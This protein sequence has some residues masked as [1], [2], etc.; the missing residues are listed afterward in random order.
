MLAKIILYN[1]YYV[2]H[3]RVTEGVAILCLHYLLI[4]RVLANASGRLP[5]TPLSFGN[6]RPTMTHQSS[7]CRNDLQHKGFWSRSP[8]VTSSLHVLHVYN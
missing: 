5:I 4:E 2:R 6:T 1:G 7:L 8:L 3:D